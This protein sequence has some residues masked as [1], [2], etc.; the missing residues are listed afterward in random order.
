[1]ENENMKIVDLS[2][3]I[4]RWS[5]VSVLV[6]K[7]MV[8][9]LSELDVVSDFVQPC[10]VEKLNSFSEN[11]NETPVEIED[12][13]SGDPSRI[14]W[15]LTKGGLDIDLSGFENIKPLDLVWEKGTK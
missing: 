11:T 7:D 1:M 13:S 8:D 9:V 5:R 4:T 12:V 10:D 14:N 6:H 15:F 2:T 3:E